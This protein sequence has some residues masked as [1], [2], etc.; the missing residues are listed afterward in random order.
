MAEWRAVP[1]CPR[2]DFPR[3]LDP[4]HFVLSPRASTLLLSNGE[5]VAC[6]GLDTFNLHLFSRE[7]PNSTPLRALSRRQLESPRQWSSITMGRAPS[8]LDSAGNE[9]R[10][11]DSEISLRLLLA[12]RWMLNFVAMS[13]SYQRTWPRISFRSSRFKVSSQKDASVER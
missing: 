11:G 4:A 2:V 3:I 12:W 9:S 13:A 5:S 1:S 6:L 8:S 10:R 7:P